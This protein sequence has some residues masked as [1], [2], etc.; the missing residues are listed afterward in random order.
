MT[1]KEWAMKMIPMLKVLVM[2]VIAVGH[3][4]MK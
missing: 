2:T 1:N 4:F 3:N